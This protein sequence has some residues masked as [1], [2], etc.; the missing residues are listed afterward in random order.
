MKIFIFFCVSSKIQCGVKSLEAVCIDRPGWSL[1]FPHC[2]KGILICPIW[3]N[4]TS[5]MLSIGPVFLAV[6]VSSCCDIDVQR[7]SRGMWAREEKAWILFV[8]HLDTCAL[9][10]QKLYHHH[11]HHHLRVS[12]TTQPRL[13][14]DPQRPSCVILLSAGITDASYMPR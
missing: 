2:S 5:G 13:S 6:N 9:C 4:Y 8:G 3:W 1:C 7:L 12:L 11:H 14:S 10:L